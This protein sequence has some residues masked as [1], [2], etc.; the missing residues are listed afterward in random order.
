MYFQIT[1][2]LAGHAAKTASWAANV[3]SE[4]GEVLISVLNASEGEGIRDMAQGLVKRYADAAETPPTLMY[5]DRDC[6]SIAGKSKVH[7]LFTPWDCHVRLDIWH[8]MRR[9]STGV[10]TDLHPL[11]AS[12]MSRL[13]GCIFEWDREDVMR[14]QNAKRAQLKAQH[15]NP[16]QVS[17]SNVK[18]LL[19]VSHIIKYPYYTYY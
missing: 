19:R 6:C 5:V 12:F 15:L 7:D 18:I 4:R 2:K 11:Y 8:F 3:G 16:R 14:L 17:Y 13:S 10:T 9:F 1:K